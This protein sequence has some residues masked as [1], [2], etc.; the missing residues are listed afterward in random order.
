MSNRHIYRE[1]PPAKR[2]CSYYR[3]QDPIRR[4][5]FTTKD[6]RL[7]HYGCWQD[8]RDEQYQCLECWGRFDATEAA[9]IEGQGC[10]SDDFRPV[11]RVIC[12]YCGSVNVKGL[13][14]VGV[15]ET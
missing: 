8:A 7:W 3:C 9:F 10:R 2:S 15:I 11:Q 5:I 12:P 13:S 6:G 4:N 14:Q 1:V